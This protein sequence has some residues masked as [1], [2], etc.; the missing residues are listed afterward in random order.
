MDGGDLGHDVDAVTILLDQLG[1]PHPASMRRSRPSSWS[2]VAS[3]PSATGLSLPFA[4]GLVGLAEYRNT[5]WGYAKVIAMNAL[6]P[7]LPQR[8]RSVGAGGC[9]RCAAARSAHRR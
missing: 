6:T 1:P 2:L 8:L 4:S 7:H 9:G 3:S 5:P